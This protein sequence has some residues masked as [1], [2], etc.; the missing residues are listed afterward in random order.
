MHI[1]SSARSP[2][3]GTPL[4]VALLVGCCAALPAGAQADA[5]AFRADAIAEGVQLFRP[6]AAKPGRANSLVVERRDGLLVVDAQPTPD[7]ARELLAEIGRRFEAP[8]RY[9]VLSHPHAEAAGGATAFPDSVLVISSAA[10]A[11]ALADPDYDFGAEERVAALDPRR[12]AEPPRPSPGL[13]VRATVD[14]LDPQRTVSLRVHARAH[15]V[16]DLTV[17][18]PQLDLLY[19]GG[20]VAIDRNPYGGDADVQRWLGILNSLI[21]NPV[22]TI[23]GVHGPPADLRA[24]SRQRDSFAWL[25]GRVE[26]GFVDRLGQREIVNSVLADP[27]LDRWFDTASLAEFIGGLT[28]QVVAEAV[29]QRRKRGIEV[30]VSPGAGATAADDRPSPGSN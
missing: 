6:A 19:T 13:A 24:V 7:A 12:W 23:V 26:E 14:L 4:A 18:I 30:P 2:L 10:C 11:A 21:A 20:L 1:D 25:R 29:T 9:L 8:V 27:D 17:H 5:A 3:R 28:E 22:S 16:G 15:S